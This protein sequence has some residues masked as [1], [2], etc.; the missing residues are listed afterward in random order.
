MATLACDVDWGAR[1]EVSV[2]VGSVA[3]EEARNLLVA[4]LTGDEQRRCAILVGKIGSGVA[5]SS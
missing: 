4:I 1:A 3:R 2:W 5:H